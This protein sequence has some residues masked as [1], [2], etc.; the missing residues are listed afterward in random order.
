MSK[1]V[2][3]AVQQRSTAIMKDRHQVIDILGLKLLEVIRYKPM[4][5][6]DIFM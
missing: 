1:K 3:D 6:Q 4:E 5:R 2:G